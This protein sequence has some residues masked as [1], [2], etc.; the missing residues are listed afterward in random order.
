MVLELC[1]ALFCAPPAAGG[2]EEESQGYIRFVPQGEHAGRLETAVTTLEGPKDLRVHLVAA[3]HVADRSYYQKLERM[4][5]K[6][7]ALLYEMVKPADYDPERD[8]K[9]SNLLSTFQRGLKEILGLEFQ[10]D[11]IDYSR[12]NFIH[13]DMDFETFQRLSKARGENILTLMLRVIVDDLKRQSRGDLSGEVS[14][15]ELLRALLS[16]DRSR[17]LKL[18]LARQFKDIEARLAGLSGEQGSVILTERNK[19]AVETLKKTISSGKKNI[20]IFFGGAHMADLERRLEG[21]GLKRKSTRW[22]VAWD[23]PPEAPP[24]GDP[25][26]RTPGKGER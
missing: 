3:V 26:A 14:G 12:K 1:L 21:M 4:F 5:E 25:P 13:A 19:V 2:S 7:D 11:A 8:E 6:Y 22:L 24:R 23:M 20:G 17:A 9:G 15:F 10:L 16:R 18:L